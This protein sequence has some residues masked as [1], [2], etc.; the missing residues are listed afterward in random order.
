MLRILASL[1]GR[2]FGKQYAFISVATYKVQKPWLI[3]FETLIVAHLVN[4]CTPEAPC[5]PCYC[6]GI[7]RREG[8]R[9]AA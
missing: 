5:N 6:Y 7:L 8:A 9:I 3:I 1:T 2:V 4:K